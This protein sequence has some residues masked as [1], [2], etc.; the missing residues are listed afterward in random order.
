MH[1]KEGYCHGDLKPNNIFVSS[2]NGQFKFYVIDF[3]WSGETDSKRYPGF[4]NLEIEWPEGASSGETLKC[5]HDIYWLDKCL[6]TT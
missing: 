6:D 5:E 4:M 3:D 1:K 2:N